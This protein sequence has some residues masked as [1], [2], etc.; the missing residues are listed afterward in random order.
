MTPTTHKKGKE[1]KHHHDRDTKT[2]MLLKCISDGPRLFFTVLS[3]IFTW[4]LS[5][6]FFASLRFMFFTFFSSV[7]CRASIPHFSLLLFAFYPSTTFISLPC[8]FCRIRWST[9][10]QYQSNLFKPSKHIS[11]KMLEC[12]S[13][14]ENP[15]CLALRLV[16][17]HKLPI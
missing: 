3:T 7:R 10:R 12:L 6:L 17:G 5:I 15:Q 16:M 9:N 1:S 2:N 8:V 13:W 4:R 11:H 14:S